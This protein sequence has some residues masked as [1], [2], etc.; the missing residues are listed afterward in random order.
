MEYG[1]L[2]ELK[3]RVKVQRT[4]ESCLDMPPK[5]SAILTEPHLL[6]LLFSE[7][8]LLAGHEDVVDT[9]GSIS[10]ALGDRYFGVR[11]ANEV[12]SISLEQSDILLLLRNITD[13]EAKHPGTTRSSAQIHVLNLL[14]ANLQISATT[15]LAPLPSKENFKGFMKTSEQV[16]KQKP[17]RCKL[18]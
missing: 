8:Y 18:P 16:K 11:D 5:L 1:H 17:T 6:T 14:F 12:E 3:D 4:L 15:A 9:L 7:S 10:G 13:P 2:V